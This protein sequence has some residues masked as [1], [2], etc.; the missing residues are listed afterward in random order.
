MK[1]NEFLHFRK[2]TFS[3]SGSPEWPAVS[4]EEVSSDELNWFVL[5]LKP[6]VLKGLFKDRMNFWN[7]LYKDASIRKDE[8]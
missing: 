3:W 2:P 1:K 5:G 7:K 4:K 8:L 6:E